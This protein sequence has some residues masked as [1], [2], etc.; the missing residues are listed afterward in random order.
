ME[1]FGGL[2]R[3]PRLAGGA[4]S[5]RLRNTNGVMINGVILR[6]SGPKV[7]AEL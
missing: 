6:L 3:S 1:R 4:G 5:V 7:G 2:P